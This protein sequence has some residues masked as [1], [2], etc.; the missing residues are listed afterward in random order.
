MDVCNIHVMKP[1]L[2]EHGFHFSKAKGQNFLIA[3]WVPEQIAEDSGVDRTV[4]VLEIG[5]GIGPLTQQLALRAGKVCAVE[6]DKRLEPILKLTVGEFDN[7]EII[8]DDVLKLNVPE[9]VKEKFGDLRPMAC[10]NLPYYITSPIL[11]ALLEA[12]CFEAVTVMVQKEVAQRIAAKPG[13]ADYSAFT[14]F[15]QYYAEPQILFDVPAGCFMPQPK[16][17]SA[18]ITLRT[19]KELPWDVLDEKIFFRVVRAS[20]AMRRKTLQN[21]LASG[22]PELGKAGAGAV[23]EACGLPASVRG[24]T[25]DIPQ[26]AKIANEIVRRRNQN[27]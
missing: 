5:P 25:L 13:T 20:F 16:V 10:A 24:E 1:L 6:L 19:R 23:I 17:T 12:G 4:G 26:F 27:V 11:T 3:G 18:V 14:I 15:C 7:L 9:L 21:G 22:F 2:A 8:W